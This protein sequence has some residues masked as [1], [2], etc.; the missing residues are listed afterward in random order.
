M[1]QFQIRMPPSV[2]RH[3][4]EMLSLSLQKHREAVALIAP[5]HGRSKADVKRAV[6][7]LDETEILLNDILTYVNSMELERALEELRT[8]QSLMRVAQN[9]M[10]HV[11]AD[12]DVKGLGYLF[13]A[14]VLCVQLVVAL[15]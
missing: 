2:E 7:L 14:L 9:S 13:L 12:R 6:H 5:P 1:S 8:Q 3:V 10:E 11:T 4:L 15:Y